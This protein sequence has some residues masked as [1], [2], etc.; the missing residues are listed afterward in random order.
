M[1]WSPPKRKGRLRG[2]PLS[3][4]ESLNDS[5]DFG[6]AS[7]RRQVSRENPNSLYRLHPLVG[8][9][10]RLSLAYSNPN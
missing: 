2:A 4:F 9:L 8:E 1:S 10:V 7:R 5:A 3:N 6:L